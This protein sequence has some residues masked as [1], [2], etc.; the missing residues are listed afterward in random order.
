MEVHQWYWCLAFLRFSMEKKKLISFLDSIVLILKILIIIII[1]FYISGVVQYH[2]EF[3]LRS[4]GQLINDLDN[5]DQVKINKVLDELENRANSI[6][7]P[8]IKTYKNKI[9]YNSN[10]R[11]NVLYLLSRTKSPKITPILISALND[12][13]EE[14]NI[15]AYLCL[16]LNLDSFKKFFIPILKQENLQVRI[17]ILSSLIRFHDINSFKDKRAI[18]FFINLSKENHP[19]IKILTI[20]ILDQFNTENATQAIIDCLH[21]QNPNVCL[22]ATR[23]LRNKENPKLIDH[24]LPNLK[25]N[26]LRIRI[27]T[28]R[29]LSKPI[30]SKALKKEIPSLIKDKDWQIRYHSV[31]ALGIMGDKALIPILI[32]LIEDQDELIASTAAYSLGEI[33][34]KSAIPTL[35]KALGIQK[36]TI[37]R[38]A[39]IALSK[40][41][42]PGLESLLTFASNKNHKASLRTIALQE[43]AF[44]KSRH[45][46]LPLIKLLRDNNSNIRKYTLFALEKIND[47]RALEPIRKIAENDIDNEIR[48]YARQA[49]K[50]IESQKNEN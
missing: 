34:H 15:M 10:I 46:V 2:I 36:P 50:I 8:L 45:A 38:N 27:E 12:N 40:I 22:I 16:K 18:D 26:D 4:T 7:E 1:S 11:K 42:I 24:L 21:N 44:I 39:L 47:Q 41:G 37:Q 31:M 28:I 13:D 20:K 49:I 48:K 14:I 33:G 9:I 29:V 17:K 3:P 5:Y 25:H 35:V 30:F 23:T 43:V 6:I 19:I 32:G